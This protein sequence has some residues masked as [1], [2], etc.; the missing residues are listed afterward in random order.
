MRNQTLEESLP[1]TERVPPPCFATLLVRTIALSVLICNI[2]TCPSAAL[3][4]FGGVQP[5]SMREEESSTT[6]R[7][8]LEQQWED[9]LH[10]QCDRIG[11]QAQT[12]ESLLKTLNKI[13]LPMRLDQTALDDACALDDK[14]SV[15]QPSLPLFTRLQVALRDFNATIS[16]GRGSLAIVSL[17][18]ADDPEN[19]SVRVYDISGVDSNLS[20]TIEM[21]Q[22]LFEG[23][24]W[25]Q[26][27][28]VRVVPFPT[29]KKSMIVVKAAYY[30][31]VEIDQLLKKLRANSIPGQGLPLSRPVGQSQDEQSQPIKLPNDD[32]KPK[33]RMSGGGGGV[34]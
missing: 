3:G 17:D 9:I 27:D 13:G 32:R 11:T 31:Q 12:F 7:I 28:V 2:A 18:C 8:D 34:F 19:L 22:T 21:I 20:T 1:T 29:K 4:Q 10:R 25:C 5:E 16:M 14:I 24:S 15:R 26:Q 6:G 30:R 33:G 23:E